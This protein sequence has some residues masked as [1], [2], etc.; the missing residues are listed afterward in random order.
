MQCG[1]AGLCWRVTPAI[2]YDNTLQNITLLGILTDGHSLVT[3]GLPVLCQV[4]GAD[5]D[6]L[7]NTRVTAVVRD[8]DTACDNIDGLLLHRFLDLRQIGITHFQQGIIRQ[9]LR[10]LDFRAT[11]FLCPVN[12]DHVDRSTALAIRNSLSSMPVVAHDTALV[13]RFTD[14]RCNLDSID[15]E[16]SAEPLE[17]LL[18]ARLKPGTVRVHVLRLHLDFHI[19][20]GTVVTGLVREHIDGRS[21]Q[22]DEPAFHEGISLQLGRNDGRGHAI[23]YLWIPTVVINEVSLIDTAL[24]QIDIVLGRSIGEPDE[25]IG[26]IGEMQLGKFRILRHTTFIAHRLSILGNLGHRLGILVLNALQLLARNAHDSDRLVTS[27]QIGHA[28]IQAVANHGCWTVHIGIEGQSVRLQET[29]YGSLDRFGH[30]VVRKNSP[31]Q[32]GPVVLVAHGI[33][34]DHVHITEIRG[35]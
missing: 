28:Y 13:N 19:G 10:T 17:N 27:N 33:P 20:T 23:L 7:V 29:A 9:M 8:L 12:I 1:L 4:G 25:N 5:V 26:N 24:S 30:G 6:C 11:V 14:E 18:R 15:S 2:R 3:Y 35:A 34:H 31:V 21:H 16:L 22:V 32:V